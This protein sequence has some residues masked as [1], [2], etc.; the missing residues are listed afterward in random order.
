MGPPLGL[1]FL[2]RI[3]IRAHVVDQLDLGHD[4]MKA[5]PINMPRDLVHYV[6]TQIMNL[7]N[8]SPFLIIASV[9]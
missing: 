7:S 9:V 4:Q 8:M 3:I 2:Q 6:C 5:Q 1:S